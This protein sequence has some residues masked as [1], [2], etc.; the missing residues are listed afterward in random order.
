MTPNLLKILWFLIPL[1]GLTSTLIAWPE[2]DTLQK[3]SLSILAV[4]SLLCWG[5]LTWRISGFR[6]HLFNF[7][8]LLLAGDY[9]TGIRTPRRFTDEISTLENIA[10]KFADRLRAYDRL[11]ADRVSIHARIR[12][13]I[14]RYTGDPLITADSEK[15]L[16]VFNPAAQKRLGIT[17]KN[18][19]FDAVL[20]PKINHAFARLFT[21][22]VEGR[23]V[24]TAGSCE[25]QLPGMTTPVDLSLLLMPLRDR[26]ENVRYTLI[27]IDPP[28]GQDAALEAVDTTVAEPIAPDGE[29]PETP[30]P[31]S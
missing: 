3:W 12:D 29:I 24:N 16:F 27:A 7:L 1:S 6:K 23:K 14:L 31:E 10:N 19:T 18:Y 26:E 28:T 5:Y 25:I 21:S 4:L 11:R 8:R 9:E 2:I 17:P 22:A 13:L 15:E 20:S 30:T